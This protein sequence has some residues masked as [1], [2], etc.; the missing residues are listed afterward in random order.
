[1]YSSAI[2]G[3]VILGLIL[4]IVTQIL[5]WMGLGTSGWYVGLT[6]ISVIVVAI[7]FVRLL[8][9]LKDGQ[10]SFMKML[11][12]LGILII[13]SRYIFQLYMYVY[14][15]HI[16]PSWVDTIAATWT[17]MMIDKEMATDLMD[18]Q[19]AGFRK[20]YETLPMFTTEIFK[21]AISQYVL[22]LMVAG[23]YYWASSLYSSP[24]E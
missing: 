24:T 12:P 3:G 2:K 10:P 16:D 8:M 19:I 14:I 15:H 5:T 17:E 20:A 21:I 23:I 7:F 13:I 6:Y 11:I 18:T 9:S 22:G 4:V 1:M